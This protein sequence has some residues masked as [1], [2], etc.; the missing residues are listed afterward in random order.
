MPASATANGSMTGRDHRQ[1]TDFSIYCVLT[2]D[3]IELCQGVRE[4]RQGL[5]NAIRAGETSCNCNRIG[6]FTT[7]VYGDQ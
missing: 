4:Y 6:S 7:L 3:V 2:K 5:R 1:T